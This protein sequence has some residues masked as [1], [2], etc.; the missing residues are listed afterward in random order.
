MVM[1]DQWY[2][3]IDIGHPVSGLVV[4]EAQGIIAVPFHSPDSA[5]IAATGVRFGVADDSAIM[6]ERSPI[7]V[8]GEVI[9]EREAIE[10]VP[11]DPR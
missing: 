9:T 1:P 7:V 3:I 10:A 5:A 2:L 11:D 4:D 8:A 6:P